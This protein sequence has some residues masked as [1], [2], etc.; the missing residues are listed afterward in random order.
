MHTFFG[1][2]CSGKRRKVQPQSSQQL[3]L[4]NCINRLRSNKT[5]NAAAKEVTVQS[6]A[7]LSRRPRRSRTH[8]CK[9]ERQA[10]QDYVFPRK[11]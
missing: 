6:A 9:A 7:V 11:P 4:G 1:C 3:I 10:L 2:L 8:D 5:F